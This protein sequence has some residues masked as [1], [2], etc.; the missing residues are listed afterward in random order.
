MR[1]WP[2]AQDSTRPQLTRSTR[3][4]LTRSTRPQSNW[5]AALCPAS[6]IGA[7]C[8]FTFIVAKRGHT[9]TKGLRLKSEK[10]MWLLIPTPMT[11][12]L[13]CKMALCYSLQH[14][15]S[16]LKKFISYILLPFLLAARAVLYLHMSLTEWVI[17]HSSFR[18]IDAAMRASGQITSN[19]LVY[20][21][22][23]PYA[24]TPTS[25]QIR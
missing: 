6:H 19:F 8:F 3:P 21:L 23:L 1:N 25:L 16:F 18:A 9:W 13:R 14:R 22:Q 11:Q 15:V 17:H 7:G 5:G 10:T 20:N 12:F 4:Q 2:I 24:H